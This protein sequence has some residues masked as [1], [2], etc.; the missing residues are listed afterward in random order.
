MRNEILQCL[1]NFIRPRDTISQPV[2]ALDLAIFTEIYN[3]YS[4]GEC[5]E[6]LTKLMLSLSDST[7]DPDKLT[8]QYLSIKKWGQEIGEGFYPAQTLASEIVQRALPEDQ[9]LKKTVKDNIHNA[10]NIDL[11]RSLV[12][13]TMAVRAFSAIE[14]PGSNMSIVIIHTRVRL[15]KAKEY[16]DRSTASGE[17]KRETFV[18]LGEVISNTES[19]FENIPVVTFR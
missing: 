14:T 9:R 10:T 18:L 17:H 6:G 12:C 19:A 13:I 4:G 5:P 16:M 15:S 11:L 2:P 3:Y 8:D 1:K 7:S